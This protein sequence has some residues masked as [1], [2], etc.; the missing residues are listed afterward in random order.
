MRN[1]SL[2]VV[3]FLCFLASAFAGQ[4]HQ[5]D[6]DALMGKG[7]QHW[8]HLKQDN[9]VVFLRQCKELYEKNILLKDAREEETRIPQKIHFIW[10]GPK[11]LPKKYKEN[12][13]SW[14]AKHPGWKFIL[15]SDRPRRAPS[16]EVE[17]R[18]VD[19]FV[20]SRLKDR[21]FKSDKWG[22]KAD[23]LCYEILFQEGGL[24]A[25]HDA[26]CLQSFDTLNRS[27]DMFCCLEAPHSSLAG[28]NLT[29]SNGV[30]GAKPLH[31][32]VEKVMNLIDTRWDRLEEELNK[33]KNKA[34]NE[35]FIQRT[36]IALTEA[37][38]ETV[39]QH[40]ERDIVLPSGYFFAKDEISSLYTKTPN[41]HSYADCDYVDQDFE[42]L[43]SSSFHRWKS[44]DKHVLSHFF[45]VCALALIAVVMLFAILLK[46]KQRYFS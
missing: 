40:P 5:E 29:C 19:T 17:V 8:K 1:W 20:F 41:T 16:S 15:W 33:K 25:Y 22:E 42:R 43:I 3:F 36:Y 39:V 13:Q 34:K 23:I 45:A 11:A 10:L 6:F 21:F 44:K 14:V 27:Y 31:P 18:S 35:V 28:L 12:I 7:T 32:T 9:E 24:Y 37:V 46:I 30:I 38:K 2:A 26:K 4:L